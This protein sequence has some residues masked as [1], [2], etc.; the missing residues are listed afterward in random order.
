MPPPWCIRSKASVD[1]FE[2][3]GVGDHRVD[4]DATVACTRRH[5]PAAAIVRGRRRTP[6]RARRAG[7]QLERP[8]GIS[9]P[10]P[11]T[12]MMTDSPQP[13]WQHSSAARI[14]CTLPMHSK[15]SRRRRRSCRRSLPGSAAFVLRCDELG[16][17]RV[18]GDLEFRRVDVDGDDA[19]GLGFHCAHDAETDAAQAENGHGITRSYL[20]RVEHRADAG[21]DAAA[22]QADFFQRRFWRS[23]RRRFPATRCTRR[24]S[25][26]PCSGN[27]LRPCRKNAKC[28]R[29]SSLCPGSHGCAAKVGVA[30]LAEFALAAFGSVQ[31][32]HMIADRHGGHAGADLPRPSRRLHG[33]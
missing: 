12:P 24:T 31:R 21:G 30:R 11:A 17:T 19:R 22:Q 1:P 26:C 20:G 3:H 29:A 18:L 28:H 7:D 27:R 13:L 4:L 25:R 15:E 14:T 6:S 33:P 23:W 10:A 8:G 9:W 16:C 5:S 2:R 32:D